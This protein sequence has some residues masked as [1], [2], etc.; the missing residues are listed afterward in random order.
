MIV[1]RYL[2]FCCDPTQVAG[3]PDLSEEQK[4]FLIA[5]LNSKQMTSSGQYLQLSSG[6][7]GYTCD[8]NGPLCTVY[9]TQEIAF[10]D[11]NS[12]G[13]EDAAAITTVDNGH[14]YI[15]ELSVY[16]NRNGKPYSLDTIRVEWRGVIKQLRIDAGVITLDFWSHKETDTDCCPTQ[17]QTW[18]LRLMNGRL[19]LLH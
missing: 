6:V 14:S 12:D 9:L 3:R 10:G 1:P 17:A 15:Q 13:L 11:L 8:I 4:Q 18:H 7:G 19:K 2:Q 16:I 5:L